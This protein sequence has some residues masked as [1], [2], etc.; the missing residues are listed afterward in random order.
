MSKSACARA[1][2]IQELF[3]L[4]ASYLSPPDLL[5]CIRVNHHWNSYFVPRLW[6]TIDDSLQS[7][8][9]IL[10]DC[11]A[12]LKQSL[13]GNYY[14][15]ATVNWQGDWLK[16]TFAKYGHL[17]RKLKI[18]WP[19]LVDVISN[20]EACTNLQELKIDIQKRSPGNAF[21]SS[22][23][24]ERY[25]AGLPT[26]LTTSTFL[27]NIVTPS[28]QF[29]DIT[30][31]D[32]PQAGFSDIIHPFF[33][34]AF[35]V[36]DSDGFRV[37]VDGLRYGLIFT[38]VYWSLVLANT[39]LQRLYLLEGTRNQ[40]S[41]RTPDFIFKVISGMWELREVE[42]PDS[43]HLSHIPRLSEVA[44]TVDTVTVPN[45]RA[46]LGKYLSEPIYSIKSLRIVS[47]SSNH[48]M[49]MAPRI[50][51]VFDILSLCPNLEHLALHNIGADYVPPK[52]LE[53]ASSDQGSNLKKLHVLETDNLEPLLHH[54]PNL[55]E[56]VV[57]YLFNE[58][59]RAVATCCRDLEV[60]EWR[61]DPAYINASSSEPEE[62]DALHQLLASC[63]NLRVFNGIER[64]IMAKNCIQEPWACM[65]IEK[66]RCRIVGVTRLTYEEQ[67]IYDRLLSTNVIHHQEELTTAVLSGLTE[68]ERGVVLK[69][70]NS[71]EQQRWVYKRLASLERLKHLDIGFEDRDPTTRTVRQMY[72]SGV[73]GRDYIRYEP[74]RSDT[75]ELSLESGLG[76]LGTLKDLEMF[77]FERV[78]HRIQEKELEWMASSWPKLKLIYGL[79]E[80]RLRG[81]ER[82]RER[83]KLRGYMQALQPDVSHSSLFSYVT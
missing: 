16:S 32:R 48:N 13:R 29:F 42:M 54:I 60:L 3:D 36:P 10:V 33:D 55:K 46:Q 74:P 34:G 79:A 27:D 15:K 30:K 12:T 26:I 57:G 77:G 9:A 4:I 61:R 20:S 49:L 5:A 66:L 45:N 23:C 75:L 31:G 82:D 43:L 24:R 37:D 53:S 35:R 11:H 51:D 58:T 39:G 59:F 14:P 81:L 7:W 83:V 78:D 6:H 50:R 67:T 69:S 62:E 44:P 22:E 47:H 65:G 8:P 52:E 80:E 2:D 71:R 64:V 41:T 40:W 68:E 19:L 70:Y 25:A 72:T 73:D 21:W 56:L 76:L 17:I 63:S 18:S 38:Q 1:F 28:M